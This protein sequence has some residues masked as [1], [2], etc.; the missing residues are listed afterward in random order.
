MFN[1]PLEIKGELT[2]K[3]FTLKAFLNKYYVLGP[4]LPNFS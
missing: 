3:E 1:W 4:S 2:P